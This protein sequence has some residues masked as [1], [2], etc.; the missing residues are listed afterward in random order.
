MICL[1]REI[2]KKK[3]ILESRKPFNLETEKYIKELSISELIFSSNKLDGSLLTIEDTLAI[4]KGGYL[5]NRTILDHVSVRNYIDSIN[6]I[7]DLLEMKDE[8]TVKILCSIHDSLCGSEDFGYRTAN[9]ILHYL[10]YVPPHF[11]GIPE[12]IEKLFSWYYHQG[13]EMN[14][15]LR[16]SFLHCILIEIYPF[17]ELTEATARLLLNY[18]FLFCGFPMISFDIK[19]SEYYQMIEHYISRRDIHPFYEMILQALDSKLNLLLTLT[20]ND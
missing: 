12:R 16:A 7:D 1:I 3:V 17:K 4:I 19:E 20:Q 18:E 9:P 6:K 8:M 2:N 15:V 14:V 13:Q 10:N 5:T 11:H